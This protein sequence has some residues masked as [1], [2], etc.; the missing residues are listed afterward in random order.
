MGKSNSKGT[1]FEGQV[2]DVLTTLRESN[3]ECIEI[4]DHPNFKL[5]NQ[6]EV[7]P[8]FEIKIKHGYIE[9]WYLI[10]C[11][12]RN[13]SD[14]ELFRKIRHVKNLSRR[15]KFIFVHGSEISVE[16]RRSLDSDGIIVMSFQE[17]A[18]FAARLSSELARP[19][20]S[21]I[22]SEGRFTRFFDDDDGPEN[23]GPKV[24]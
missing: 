24:S 22:D 11:Q 9:D 5:F 4:V 16:V 19:L 17:F 2:W 18:S 8:D 20:P 12:N 3:P 6:E 7:I 10:E 21:H 13:R 1:E 23:Y 14:K 15:N